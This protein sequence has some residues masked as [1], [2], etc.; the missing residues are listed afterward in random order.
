MNILCVNIENKF[1]VNFF[2]FTFYKHT[3]FNKISKL[4]ILFGPPKYID[5]IEIV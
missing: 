3:L 1:L 5:N 4:K 2:L